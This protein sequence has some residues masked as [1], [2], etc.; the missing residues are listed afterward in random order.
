MVQGATDRRAR[1]RAGPTHGVPLRGPPST[2]GSRALSGRNDRP[3]PTTRLTRPSRRC[4]GHWRERTRPPARWNAPCPPSRP[5]TSSSTS[6][7]PDDASEIEALNA[8]AFGP[9]RHARAAARLRERGPHDLALS[10]TARRGGDLV[11]SVRLTPIDVGGVPGHLLGPLAVV[12]ALKSLGIG[13]ALIERSCAAAKDAGEGTFVL[14]VGDAPYYARTGFEVVRGPV[15][16]GPVDPARL[17]VRWHGAPRAIAG[18]VRH[19]LDSSVSSHPVH[20]S[21][22]ASR[23]GNEPALPPV[24]PPP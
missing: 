3:A 21:L 11:G 13:R 18:P 17:L 12:P 19:A 22:T 5:P 8:A 20:P 10:F 16:P 7:T 2:R 4:L 1:T 14:L 24:V 23:N 9:G 15:M 6:R